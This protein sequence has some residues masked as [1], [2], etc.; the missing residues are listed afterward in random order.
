MLNF[1]RFFFSVFFRNIQNACQRTI[2]YALLSK[3]AIFAVFSS[4][5]L[6]HDHLI[7][8]HYVLSISRQTNELA[9][10]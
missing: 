8:I 6:A 3:H 7:H 1:F 4:C 9:D 2:N 10:E 5:L